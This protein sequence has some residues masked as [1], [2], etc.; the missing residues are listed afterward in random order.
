TLFFRRDILERLGGW[1]AHNVTEDA[2]LGLR[3]A[4]HGYRT[5][6]LSTVTMEEANCR[7]WP[8]IKQRSRWLKGYAMTYA[9]HMRNPVLLWQQLGAWRFAG[10][11]LLYLGTLVQF[12]LAPILWSFWGMLLG[13]GHPLAEALP[14]SAM[15]GLAVLFLTSE[16]ISLTINLIA[17]KGQRHRFL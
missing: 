5:D 3:L 15:V 13:L 10:V 1:D 12:L 9:V 7:I 17:L 11:Q 16:L 4:R 14:R 8:W 2:D 6:L